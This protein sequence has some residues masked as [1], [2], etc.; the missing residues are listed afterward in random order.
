MDVTSPEARR[1]YDALVGCTGPVVVGLDFD[2]TLSP[3]VADPAQARIHPAAPE[4]LAA[5]A[6]TVAAIAVV[7]GRPVAHVLEHAHVVELAETLRSAGAPVL[8]LGQYGVERWSS[9]DQRT[10]SPE[11]PAAL[12]AL[13]GELPGL[14]E[15][16][17][18]DG[19]PYVEDK[20]LAF[21]VHTRRMPDPRTAYDR[22]LAALT[23]AA[24][25]HGLHVEPGRYVVEVRGPGGDKGDAVRAL[26]EE[27]GAQG[28]V[29]VGD[30]LGD[31]PAFDAVR[32]LGE[33]GV[34]DL[35]VA[36]GSTEQRALADR[37]DVVVDG[38][39]GVVAFL[40]RLTTDRR[41]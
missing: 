37:A 13:A 7:T 15:E 39:D 28:F 4:A 19:E 9:T 17:E 21:A 5:L 29:F 22:V 25:R 3:I 14:L 34:A 1:R 18:L 23:E 41:G 6:G 33:R 16:L 27:F 30:D 12:T 36:S 38:P 10:V 24:A 20:G 11:P 32:A 26:A 8:V 31:L 40:R 2:G 35:L